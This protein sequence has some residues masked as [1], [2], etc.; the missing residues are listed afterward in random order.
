[1]NFRTCGCLLAPQ[2]GITLHSAPHSLSS[3]Y[4]MVRAPRPL[5]RYWPPYGSHMVQRLQAP[6]PRDAS[7]QLSLPS[8]HDDLCPT[9][10]QPA[11]MLD[12]GQ[13]DLGQF[14]LGQFDLGQFDSG[15]FL[16]AQTFLNCVVWCGEVWCV[17]CGVVCSRFSWVRP[18]F[19]PPSV[20]PPSAGPPKISRFCSSPATIFIHSSL[21]LGVFSWNSGGVCW[22]GPSNV[23]VWALQTCTFQGPRASNTRRPQEREER[24]KIVAGE[25]KKS[26]KFWAPTLLGATL[27]GH[28]SGPHPFR[29]PTLR[30][31][32]FAHPGGREGG[33]RIG[34]VE[35]ISMRFFLA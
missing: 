7:T 21:S 32:V 28:P 17:V 27:R 33:G 9:C 18:R 25:G 2:G 19:A 3:S 8:T 16:V 31:L 35:K 12:L 30:G 10:A 11:R 29:G 14:D 34:L 6:C 20:G 5:C 1:M 13:F 23:H 4:N 24:K 15:Q 22:R 26:S